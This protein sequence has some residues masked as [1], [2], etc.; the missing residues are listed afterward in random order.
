MYYT[1]V[2]N[3]SVLNTGSS[4]KPRRVV[5]LP[6]LC[7]FVFLKQDLLPASAHECYGDRLQLHL[8]YALLELKPRAS[9]M[10]GKYI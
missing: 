1:S 6:L 3:L 7:S 10:L 2:F 9:Y 8:V 5:P 4:N